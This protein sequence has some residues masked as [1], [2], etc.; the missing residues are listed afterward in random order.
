MHF[1]QVAAHDGVV[2]AD[3]QAGPI[4]NHQLAIPTMSW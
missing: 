2:Q 3:A 4:G 1:P